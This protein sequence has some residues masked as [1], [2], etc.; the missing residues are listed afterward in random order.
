MVIERDGRAILM[1]TYTLERECWLPRPVEEIFAFFADP[2][3]LEALT[4]PS[5]KFRMLTPRSALRTGLTIEYGLRVRGVPIRWRSL[6]S[7]YEPG[8]RFVDEQLKGPYRLWVHEHTFVPHEG[9]TL[10]GDRVTYAVPLGWL[11]HRWLVRPD[12][13]RIFDYRRAKLLELF[14]A[15]T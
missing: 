11:V 13:E 4:P 9:G 7:A 10:C 5:L 3:N 2:G 1:K 12:L 14:P 8:K 6:I 15:R